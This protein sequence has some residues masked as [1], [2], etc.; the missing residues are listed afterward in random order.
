MI[1]DLT[2]RTTQLE[3]FQQ[4]E[5]LGEEAVPAIIYLMD[6]FRKL[7]LQQISLTCPPGWFE[8]LRHYSPERVVDALAAILNQL[9]G[10][11]FGTMIYNGDVSKKER[12]RTIDG[13][14]IYGHYRL[15]NAQD[16][17]EQ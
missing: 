13:W 12:K 9:T 1:H 11:S 4:L 17:P 5:A 15:L 16:R 14:R 10:K 6:D 7:P 2:K 8:A 3:N